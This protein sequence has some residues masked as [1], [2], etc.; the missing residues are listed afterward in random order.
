MVACCLAAGNNCL[1]EKIVFILNKWNQM[2]IIVV[3]YNENPLLRIL[4]RI[5]VRQNVQQAVQAW[6]DGLDTDVPLPIPR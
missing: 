6:A 2:R 3:G 4:R 5:R 1:E